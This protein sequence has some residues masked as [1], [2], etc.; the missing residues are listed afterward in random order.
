MEKGVSVSEITE[1]SKVAGVFLVSEASLGTARNGALYWSLKLSD[2]TGAIEAKIWHPLSAAH[3]RI[4]RGSLAWVSGRSALY[5]EKLQLAIDDFSLLPPEVSDSFD[6][7]LFLPSASIPPDEMFLELKRLALE[8]FK[9][10]P[11]R[12]FIISILN[13]EKIGPSL[14]TFPAAKTMHHAYVGGLLEHTLSVFNLCRDFAD[15]YPQLD[16]QTLLAGAILHDIG[17]ISEFSG[18]LANDYTDAGRL[19]GHIVL[20]VALI[21][22]FAQKSGLDDKLKEHLYHL[23]LS[24]HGQYE[25]GAARLPQTAEAFAL[26]YAD[27][28]DAKLAQFRNLFNDESGPEWSDYQKGMERYLYN[29]FRTPEKRKNEKQLPEFECLSLLKE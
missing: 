11:W 19:S 9:Y 4:P 1:N 23:I 13:D 25:F 26:H 8:E 24:H 2:S 27:N 5:R 22:P 14:K 3:P 10:P 17:K 28:L 7:A 6:P 21:E 16:R 29:P 18:G 12:K 20:G 15:R